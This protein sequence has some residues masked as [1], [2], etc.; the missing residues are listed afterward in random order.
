MK[1]FGADPTSPPLSWVD[2]H[3]QVPN[4]VIGVDDIFETVKAFGGAGYPF[5]DKGDCP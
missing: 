4:L 5:K 1:A 3:P 2:I